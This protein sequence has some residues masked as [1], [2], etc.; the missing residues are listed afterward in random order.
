MTI[1]L[2]LGATCHRPLW[3]NKSWLWACIKKLA[4]IFA[5]DPDVNSRPSALNTGSALPLN[6]RVVRSVRRME[7]RSCGTVSNTHGLCQIIILIHSLICL[8][9]IT[10][11]MFFLTSITSPYLNLHGLDL[12]LYTYLNPKL[13]INIFC[14]SGCKWFSRSSRKR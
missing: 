14:F 5:Q 2:L 3:G 13:N 11:L 6:H 1:I 8:L 12:N 10:I 7:T 9:Y 4:K